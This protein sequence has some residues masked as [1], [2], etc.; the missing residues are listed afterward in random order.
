MPG[1]NCSIFGCGTSRAKSGISI[2][3][4]PAG[5]DENSAKIRDEWVR[6]VCRDREVDANLRKQIKE[7]DSHLP[8]S[9]RRK[10][11]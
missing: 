10:I 1:A 2:F 5:D 4:I 7:N 8:E 3:K 11:H 6:V 9:F